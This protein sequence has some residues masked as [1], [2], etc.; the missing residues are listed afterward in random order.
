MEK[1]CRRTGFLLAIEFG[2]DGS[3]RP[4]IADPALFVYPRGAQIEQ[5]EI[6]DVRRGYRAGAMLQHSHSRCL[7]KV[8]R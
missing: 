1:H 7:L 3:P 8:C 6:P 2:S 4:V 5:F